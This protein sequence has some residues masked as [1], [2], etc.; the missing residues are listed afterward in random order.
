MAPKTVLYLTPSVRMLGARQSLLALAR[1]LDRER[2]WPLV[3]C[4]SPGGLT[5]AL[6]REGVEC[7]FLK[8]G[9]WR[10][11]RYWPRL[12]LTVARLIGLIRRRAVDLIHC[13]EI[14]PNPFACLAGGWT[15]RPVVTHMRLSVT[16]RLARHYWLR[17]ADRIIVVSEAAGRDF[18]FWPD[19]AQRVRVI[20]NGVDFRQF[21]LR[22]PREETRRELGWPADAFVVG[23]IAT[24]SHRKRQHIAIEAVRELAERFPRLLLALVG[25]AAQSQ[26]EYES[27]LR[28][29]IAEWGLEERVVMRP[30]TEDVASLCHA[31]DVNIL[32]SGDEGFGR[33]IIEAGAAGR[34]SIGARVGGIP[35]LIRDGLSGWLVPL[36]D[37]RALARRIESLLT[38]P[39]AVER[40][41]AEA[42]RDAQERFSVEKHARQVQ[43]VYDEILSERAPNK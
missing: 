22:R 39:L 41:G 23:H 17:R 10:K 16:P 18:D 9:W 5:Q 31:I 25:G 12:P 28:S 42:R 8:T 13:N 19:K 33:T 2:Y 37:P 30:F 21:Q 20:H 43:A 35:E 6:E 29:M 14:Y 7:V 11:A 38:D 3:C 34:P 36:D 4:Q 15:G 32:I 40:A 27:A 1:G 26:R 24:W